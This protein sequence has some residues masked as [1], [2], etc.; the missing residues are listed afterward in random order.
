M[1]RIF[2]SGKI[3]GTDNYKLRFK[4]CEDKLI[5]RNPEALIVN[6]AKI[7]NIIGEDFPYSTYI[8]LCLTMLKECDMIYMML[9]WEKS[10]GAQIEHK[11]AKEHSI[12]IIYESEV[13]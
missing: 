13:G 6:P 11:F 2:I 10:T 12:F 4:K 5:Y 8:D 7:S 1:D 9:D 3:T